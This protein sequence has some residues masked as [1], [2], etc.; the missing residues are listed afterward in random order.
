[1]TKNV[2]SMTGYANLTGETP[3][4]TLSL[5]CRSVNSRFLD[6]TLRLPDELRSVEGPV[7][8]LIQD[9]IARGKMEVRFS[10]K[11]STSNT[12]LTINEEALKTLLS[13]QSQILSVQSN[14]HSLSVAQ[15]LQSPD[16][17]NTASIDAKA[18]EESVLSLLNQALDLFIAAREREGRS[19]ANVL[20]K[21]CDEIEKTVNA[22][23]EK[24]PLILEAIQNKLE[25]RLN[26]ALSKTLTDNSTLSK[27]EISD[28]I[29]QEVTLYALKMDVEEE[30]NRL[31]THLVEVRRILEKGGAVGRRLDFMV[32][33]MNR[34]ANTLGSKAAAIEMTNA[35]MALKL[36][37]EQMREQIQNL[38]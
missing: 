27:E 20:L 16:I 34:E 24:L 9:R 30:M 26:S 38:E 14:A 13:L 11:K 5:E 29:R 25:E 12:N 17:L 18:L 8:A 32:Q 23:N 33:E 21:N 10:L 7:R 35:S 36:N 2:A 22:V 15:I 19:L 3:L 4:G 1:M 31:R 6:L 37:I 28:R